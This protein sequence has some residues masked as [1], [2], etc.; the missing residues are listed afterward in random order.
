MDTTELSRALRDAT[1]GL[2]APPDLAAAVLRGGKRRRTRRRAVLAGG[3]AVVIAAAGLVVVEVT[4]SNEPQIAVAANPMLTAP[5]RGDLAGDKAYLDA[6][7][8]AFDAGMPDEPDNAR[9]GRP[10]VYWAG[11]TDGGK[12]AVVAQEVELTRASGSV[13]GTSVVGLLVGTEPVLVNSF[14]QPYGTPAKGFAFVY[15]PLNRDVIALGADSL[16]ISSR[17]Q[18]NPTA[19]RS[20]RTD[21]KPMVK[22]DGLWF[23]KADGPGPVEDIRVVTGDPAKAGYDQSLTM[24]PSSRWALGI[25]RQ[26]KPVPENVLRTKPGDVFSVN[27][28]RSGRLGDDVHETLTMAGLLDPLAGVS[29][30]GAQAVVD[31]Q[32]GGSVVAVEVV[33]TFVTSDLFLALRDTNNTITGWLHCEPVRRDGGGLIG[34]CVL[35]GDS[36]ILALAPG[37][38]LSYEAEGEGALPGNRVEVG[39]NAAVVPS[40]VHTIHLRDPQGRS[41]SHGLLKQ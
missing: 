27:G 6:A 14:P 2:Q 11:T 8:A 19:E 18:L 32:G 16:S 22:R 34:A 28:S 23:G 37:M 35:P 29:P 26:R 20:V 21:W 15:G 25:D 38:A 40:S 33:T 9:L 7:V 5:T 3:M 13:S 41:E 4:G 10:H 17:W 39:T 30:T 24:L 1:E 31:L 12:V 36:G